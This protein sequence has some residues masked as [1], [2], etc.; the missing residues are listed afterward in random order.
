MSQQYF[1]SLVND[2]VLKEFSNNKKISD[3]IGPY[4]VRLNTCFTRATARISIEVYIKK[5]QLFF[6]G[7][8]EF[9]SEIEC[10]SEK[11]AKELLASVALK[12][13]DQVRAEG[14]KLRDLSG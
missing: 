11:S 1:I 6:R 12:L 5:K 2:V 13:V 4:R 8:A 10:L 9:S 3:L 7:G 14:Y